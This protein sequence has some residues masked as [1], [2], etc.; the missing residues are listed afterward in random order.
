M[1][2]WGVGVF[3]NDDAQDW[4]DELLSSTGSDCLHSTLELAKTDYLEVSEG[5]RIVCAAYVVGMLLG[6]VESHGS[7]EL[8]TWL[9]SNADIDAVSLVPHA[10]DGIDRVLAADSELHEVWEENEAHYP[11]WRQSLL[12]L[13]NEL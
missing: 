13:R 8:A 5:N 12:N 10:V 2:S 9:T 7:E 3:E 1:S 4:L 6:K 11:K